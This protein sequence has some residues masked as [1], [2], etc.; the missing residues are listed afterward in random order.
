MNKISFEKIRY[1]APL[2][3][4]V[5]MIILLLL[6]PTGYEEYLSFQESDIRPA[7]VLQTDDT[8]II[9]TGLIRSGEQ[10]CELEILSGQFKGKIATG[11]NTLNGSLERDKI[12][13]VGDTALVRINY[14]DDE[15]LNV[16]MIDHYRLPYE[17]LLAAA[18]IILLFLF[19][20]RTGLRAVFSFVLTI[21]M[22]FQSTVWLLFLLVRIIPAHIAVKGATVTSPNEPTTVWIISAAT[23]L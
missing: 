6:L 14:S 13:F 12:F 16:S 18:F 5:I 23:Y 22:L 4:C 9:D 20:G 15:I 8:S 7:R 2:L 17:L 21:L 10:R 1:N 19:A 11:E 3:A